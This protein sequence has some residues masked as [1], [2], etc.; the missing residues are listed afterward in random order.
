M[1]VLDPGGED[2]VNVPY[3]SW[4]LEET[5]YERLYLG[6]DQHLQSAPA[7]MAVQASY[8]MKA[9]KSASAKGSG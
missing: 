2:R 3:S 1:A 9:T 5:Q 8:G 7:T 4:P 6:A